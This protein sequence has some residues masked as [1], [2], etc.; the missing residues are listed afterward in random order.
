MAYK[1]IRDSFK[2]GRYNGE[3]KF[4]LHTKSYIYTFK[5]NKQGIIRNRP[6]LACTRIPDKRYLTAL[7]PRSSLANKRKKT[8]SQMIFTALTTSVANEALVVSSVKSSSFFY[9]RAWNVVTGR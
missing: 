9:L 4:L 1:L 5:Y 8:A 6:D 3:V 7:L 2:K